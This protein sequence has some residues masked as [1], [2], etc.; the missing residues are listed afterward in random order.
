[1][2]K[3]KKGDLVYVKSAKFSC[4]HS[5]NKYIGKVVEIEEVRDGGE[6]LWFKGYYWSP[7]DVCYPSVLDPD[8][9]IF[10]FDESTLD[11]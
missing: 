11:I 1:M 5:M 9:E 4:G 3:Y 2:I 10:H 6:T 7:S 8:P